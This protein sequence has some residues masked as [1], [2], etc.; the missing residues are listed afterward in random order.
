MFFLLHDNC[1]NVSFVYSHIPKTGGT[2]IRG[3]GEKYKPLFK[4][5]D[6]S[7]VIKDSWKYSFSF[8]V[9]RHPIDRFLSAF[10]DF[11]D[12]RKFN[13]TL[14]SVISTLDMFDYEKAKKDTSSLE[15]F[16]F[17]LKHN[18]LWGSEQ[19]K[20]TLFQETLNTDMCDMLKISHKTPRIVTCTS[21]IQKSKIQNCVDK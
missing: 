21:T 11:K 19:M 3:G 15:Q 13:M 1:S 5:I 14:G 17:C 2:T 18:S 16:T 7:H 6:K 20:H 4:L 9:H 12:N 10:S 8:T